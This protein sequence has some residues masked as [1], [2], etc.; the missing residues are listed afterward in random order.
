MPRVSD[1]DEDE[2]VACCSIVSRVLVLYDLFSQEDIGDVIAILLLDFDLRFNVSKIDALIRVARVVPRTAM[3]IPD[4]PPDQ[5]FSLKG[6]TICSE[7]KC[8]EL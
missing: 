8:I 7:E 2:R 1:A 3:H 5:L 6:M 4:L